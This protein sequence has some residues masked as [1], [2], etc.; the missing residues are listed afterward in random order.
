MKFITINE[1]VDAL[2]K[3][4]QDLGD[5]ALDMAYQRIRVALAESTNSSHNISSVGTQTA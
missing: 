4:F 3:H 1:A 2:D 5:D